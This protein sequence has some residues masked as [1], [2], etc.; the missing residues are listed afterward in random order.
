M[1]MQVQDISLT[2]FDLRMLASLTVGITLKKAVA[3]RCLRPDRG[4]TGTAYGPSWRLGRWSQPLA[5]VGFRGPILLV[6]NQNLQT[7]HRRVL[8]EWVPGE[9]SV[10]LNRTP[11]RRQFY[12]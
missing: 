10:S 5:T 4:G 9:R 11:V 2:T 7:E 8:G 3:G 12:P 1:G 6:A